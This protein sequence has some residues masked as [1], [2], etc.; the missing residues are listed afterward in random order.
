MIL[1]ILVVINAGYIHRVTDDL[2]R[3]INAL[4]LI[5]TESTTDDIKAFQTYLNRKI[6][7]LRLT[8][9][10]PQLDR[11]AE[12]SES[13]R[14]YA[15]NGALADY[16]VTRALLLDAIEDMSRLERLWQRS[17]VGETS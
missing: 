17:K 4:P 16:Q 14:R 15:K 1:V 6:P 7:F 5:P 9:S 2:S 3:R 10:F 11:V 12:L 8:I 13:L